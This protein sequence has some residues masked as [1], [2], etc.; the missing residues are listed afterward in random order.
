MNIK[1][2]I[3][4]LTLTAILGTFGACASTKML[5]THADG[6]TI[7]YRR[8]GLTKDLREDKAIAEADEHCKRNGFKTY[9]VESE[10]QDGRFMVVRFAC[11]N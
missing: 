5:E 3:F 6:G 11:L 8:R 10:T 4:L 1:M 7:K 9:K 2:I